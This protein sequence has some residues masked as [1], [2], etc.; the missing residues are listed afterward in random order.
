MATFNGLAINKSGAG[1]TLTAPDVPE[2]DAP[3]R[4]R[5]EQ[6]HHHGGCGSQVVFSV[7][8]PTRR[9]GRTIRPGGAG[10][11]RGLLRQRGDQRHFHRDRGDRQQLAAGTLGG[12]VTA[13]VSAAWRPSARCPSTSRRRLHPDGVGLD[14]GREALP[15]PTRAPSPSRGPAPG[16][17]LGAA[18]H[19][20]AGRP[21][22]SVRR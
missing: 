12:T 9:R 19:D 21:S 2:S 13:S 14:G 16:G 8:R 3:H 18:N 10:S 5:F 17:V 20:D 6:F 4:R 15:K 22:R 7:S 11:R 1:Y